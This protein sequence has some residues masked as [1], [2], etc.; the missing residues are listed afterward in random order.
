MYI[1]KLLKDNN[2]AFKIK[3]GK[4]MDTIIIMQSISR[5]SISY[6]VATGDFLKKLMLMLFLSLSIFDNLLKKYLIICLILHHE[7]VNV[8][9]IVHE[10]TTL[11][12]T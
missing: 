10:E 9:H 11:F 4:M 6:E 5:W 3:T 7:S 8:A 2:L 12:D 1:G